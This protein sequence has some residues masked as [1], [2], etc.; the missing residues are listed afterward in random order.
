MGVFRF[1]HAVLKKLT[2]I[3]ASCRRQGSTPAQTLV[4]GFEI[5]L[6]SL[7]EVLGRPEVSFLELLDDHLR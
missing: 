7:S 4:L 3:R 6:R 2:N 1:N 5:N